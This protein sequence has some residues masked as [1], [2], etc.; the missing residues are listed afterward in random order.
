MDKAKLIIDKDFTVASVDKRL[1]GTFIE[2]ID[3]IIYGDMYNPEHPEANEQ[4]LGIESMLAV[5]MG[6]GNAE[7]AA[8]E[9]KYCNMTSG[10]YGVT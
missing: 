1:F 7:E 6:T 4:G 8:N 3:N 2:P 9:V 10:T 5:N